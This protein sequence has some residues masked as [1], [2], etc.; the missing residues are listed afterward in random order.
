MSE[1]SDDETIEIY[2]ELLDTDFDDVAWE[3]VVEDD[4]SDDEDIFGYNN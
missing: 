1:F 2:S 4:N 3:P